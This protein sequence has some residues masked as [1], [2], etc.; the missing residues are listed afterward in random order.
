MTLASF[1]KKLAN[2]HAECFES[3]KTELGAGVAFEHE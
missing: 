1:P 2:S 3:S